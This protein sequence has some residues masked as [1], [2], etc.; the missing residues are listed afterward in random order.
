MKSVIKN[1]LC[2]AGKALAIVVGITLFNALLLVLSFLLPTSVMREHVAESYPLVESESRYL[3]WNQGYTN[4]QMDFWSEYTEYG[5]AINEDSPGSIFEQAMLMRFIDTEGF[6]RDKAVINYARYKEEP[7]STQQ[8]ARYWHGIVLVMKALLLF[9]TIP[10][11]RMLNMFLNIGLL[12]IALYQ[13]IKADLKEYLIPFIT[14]I[15]F[16]NPVTMLMSVIFSAEYVMMLLAVIM[17]L[18]C[19]DKID[20][21]SGGWSIFFAVLGAITVFFSELSSP[22][23]TLGIP[24][25]VLLWRNLH[26]NVTKT[27]LNSTFYWGSAY[28]VAWMI[29]WIMCTLFTPYNLIKDAF[30]TIVE[31]ED[32]EVIEATVIERI[33]RNL[34]P[35]YT[36]AFKTLFLLAVILTIILTFRGNYVFKAYRL[37]ISKKWDVIIGYTIIAAIPFGMIICMGTGYAYVHFYMSH[38]QLAMTVISALCILKYMVELLRS[39]NM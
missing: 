37:E 26:R 6:D 39:R 24:A 5:M 33:M 10:D 12:A 11:I 8:Y 17:I 23:I 18:V 19:G 7:F 30:G 16:I 35:Y 1:E 20:K 27:V 28:V 14:A 2:I 21:L 22:A 38:R 29:K 15:L 34:W 31:Y 32:Y 36:P 25:A 13:M 9:F 4:S 3:Q